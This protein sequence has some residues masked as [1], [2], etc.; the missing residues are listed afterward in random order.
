MGGW[1]GER[2]GGS[3]GG[4]L[5]GC[6]GHRV[7]ERVGRVDG[8]LGRVGWRA[9]GWV[10]WEMLDPKLEGRALTWQHGEP[11]L[12]K[13]QL[14]SVASIAPASCAFSKRTLSAIAIVAATCRPLRASNIFGAAV[15]KVPAANAI[16]GACV[17]HWC[18]PRGLTAGG[19]AGRCVRG[20]VSGFVLGWVCGWVHPQDAETQFPHACTGQMFRPEMNCACLRVGRS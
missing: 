14:P 9:G 12:A 5:V 7:D 16:V 19:L 6:L 13:T 15:V 17:P 1:V 8:K 4:L 18:T 20:W 2:A 11:S 10:R 3:S